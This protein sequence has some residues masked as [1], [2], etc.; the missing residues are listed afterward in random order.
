MPRDYGCVL[1]PGMVVLPLTPGDIIARLVPAQLN[2]R[3]ANQVDQTGLMLGVEAG[4]FELAA[5][6]MKATIVSA[7]KLQYCGHHG[8]DTCCLGLTVATGVDTGLD[9]GQGNGL[10]RVALMI[11]PVF[12]K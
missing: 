12:I 5:M 4:Y 11:L 10:L 9:I 3:G 6:D 8:S 1:V 2:L 7:I